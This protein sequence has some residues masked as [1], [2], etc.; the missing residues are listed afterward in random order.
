MLSHLI[1]FFFVVEISFLTL[2]TFR[3]L[4]WEKVYIGHK[5]TIHSSRNELN[6]LLTPVS[7]I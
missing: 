1:N 4:K 5:E 3:I 2:N 6:S 7:K